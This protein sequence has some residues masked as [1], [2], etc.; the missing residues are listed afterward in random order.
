M[1][2]ELLLARHG[3]T[4]WSDAKRVQG[5]SNVPKLSESG[6][7]QTLTMANKMATCARSP[8]VIITSPLRRAFESALI[9]GNVLRCEIVP[10]ALLAES[11][12][13]EWEGQ[14]IPDLIH[15]NIAFRTWATAPWNYVAPDGTSP[16]NEHRLRCHDFLQMTLPQFENYK[17]V[18]IVS[19]KHTV[20]HLTAIITNATIT[21]TPCLAIE[22]GEYVRFNRTYKLT[23]ELEP[24]LIL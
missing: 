19:H 17:S 18:V 7:G 22:H 2:A 11:S 1:I 14:S 4:D 10:N 23:W 16:F 6:R 3:S 15:G 9:L 12:L 21:E 20:Q 13:D 8:I 5:S 24:R